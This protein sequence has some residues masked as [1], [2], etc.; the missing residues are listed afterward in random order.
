MLSFSLPL[1]VSKFGYRDISTV[2]TI[3]L[4]QHI[5]LRNLLSNDTKTHI[6]MWNHLFPMLRQDQP[7][8][9]KLLLMNL[10]FNRL[11]LFVIFLLYFGLCWYCD[12]AAALSFVF[13]L[14]MSILGRAVEDRLG[15]GRRVFDYGL[16]YP[17]GLGRGSGSLWCSRRWCFPS[18]EFAVMPIAGE[19]F[20]SDELNWGS[21][22]KE[23]V[24]I[25]L[26][27]NKNGIYCW[28]FVF[29]LF[30]VRSSNSFQNF[31]RI[32]C[33]DSALAVTY[34]RAWNDLKHSWS[35]VL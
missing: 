34:W 22:E 24:R 6:W 25:E 21:R 12:T 35:I 15:I 23:D 27:S 1:C 5:R 33:R 13:F 29:V 2:N 11:R 30:S 4:G 28:P 8:L 10:F 9:G 14:G 31:L 7:C 18:E 20:I 19:G 32:S 26:H 3:T 16:R 17:F